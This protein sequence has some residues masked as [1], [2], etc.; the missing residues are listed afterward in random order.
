MRTNHDWPLRIASCARLS[1]VPAARLNTRP[2]LRP[3]H[4]TCRIQTDPTQDRS[5]VLRNLSHLS[6][7]K[8]ATGPVQQLQVTHSDTDKK[9]FVLARRPDGSTQGPTGSSF[10]S[11]SI[12]LIQ[13]LL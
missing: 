4:T 8:L 5:Q 3:H 2:N 9:P 13:P 6:S 7:V 12:G 11:I 10:S 1:G